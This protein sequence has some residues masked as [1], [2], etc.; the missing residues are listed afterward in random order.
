[1]GHENW[2]RR[3]LSMHCWYFNEP[4]LRG[5]LRNPKQIAH[6]TE[7]VGRVFATAAKTAELLQTNRTLLGYIHRSQ[8]NTPSNRKTKIGKHWA[9]QRLQPFL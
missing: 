3:A 5:A 1:M 8:S 6:R 9:T 7:Y 2:V 4:D